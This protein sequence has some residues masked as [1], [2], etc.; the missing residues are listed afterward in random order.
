MN[1]YYLLVIYFFCVTIS[2]TFSQTQDVVFQKLEWDFGSII[3]MDFPPAT[4]VFKNNS[5]K[6]I[7]ILTTKA[8]YETKVMYE[9]KYIQP[10]A[11]GVIYVKHETQNIGEFADEILVYFSHSPNPVKLNIVGNNISVVDC[12]PDKT[13]MRMRTV[14]VIDI[15][16]KEPIPGAK[17]HFLHNEM[18]DI[19]AVM[20]KNGKKVMD[21]PIGIY[22]IDAVADGYKQ[23]STSRFIQKSVPIIFLELEPLDKQELSK[24]L[25]PVE[26]KD[27][28]QTIAIEEKPPVVQPKTNTPV[29]SEKLPENVYAANNIIFVIDV[30]LSMKKDNKMTYL[31]TAI[32]ELIDVLRIIDNV[33]VISYNTEAYTEL[34]STTGNKKAQIK[35]VINEM[36]P[37]GLTNGVKGLELAYTFAENNFKPNGNNQLILAT[38]G[39]F[40]GAQQSEIQ[41]IEQIQSHVSKGIIMSIVGFGNDKE[42]LDRLKKM[43]KIG[44]GQ[45]LHIQ[46]N[47]QSM[48]LLVDEIKENSKI[49]K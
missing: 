14:H 23:M 26:P 10:Q 21:L 40:S 16:S 45:F 18:T 30:S 5:S 44:G 17:V 46:N 25:E 47:E 24:P 35:K 2:N 36:A 3:S 8:K 6:P 20:D 34:E 29:Y 49:K 42:S 19:N 32:N 9:K 7:A 11:T 13:N 31:K 43:A 4:F 15:F 1:R 41:L 12:F 39:E 38:D 33:T 28:E 48:Q 37:D 22:E 27:P